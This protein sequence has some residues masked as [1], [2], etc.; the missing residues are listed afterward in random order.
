MH[1]SKRRVTPFDAHHGVG[2]R[3][4]IGREVFERPAVEDQSVFDR[5]LVQR[6]V[7]RFTEARVTEA[8]AGPI[9]ANRRSVDDDTNGLGA[10]DEQPRFRGA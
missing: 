3:S 9:H 8:S 6:R 1:E 10:A 2:V 4:A 7:H 5:G